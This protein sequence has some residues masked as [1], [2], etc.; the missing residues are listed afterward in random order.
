MG[1]KSGERGEE[2]TLNIKRF[3]LF[4]MRLHIIKQYKQVTIE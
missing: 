1:E 3:D 4:L 2:N